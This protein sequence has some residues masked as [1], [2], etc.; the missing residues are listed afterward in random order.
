MI[1]PT[2]NRQLL[3]S[4]SVNVKD[5][6]LGLIKEQKVQPD[7]SSSFFGETSVDNVIVKL[8]SGLSYQGR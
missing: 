7:V 4:A 2:M 1:E 6:D 3:L 5:S 8:N